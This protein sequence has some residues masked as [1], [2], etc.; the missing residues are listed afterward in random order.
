[1]KAENV[2]EKWFSIATMIMGMAVFYGMLLG[3]MTSIL[4]NIGTRQ[5]KYMHRFGTIKKYLVISVNNVYQLH[6]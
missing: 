3:A 5:A 1:M 2:G 6:W 4:T